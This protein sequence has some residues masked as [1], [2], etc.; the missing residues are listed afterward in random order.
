MKRMSFFHS[1]QMHEGSWAK[2]LVLNASKFLSNCYDIGGKIAQ[3][4]Y[5]F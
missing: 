2:S 5:L 4:F 1:E 3:V